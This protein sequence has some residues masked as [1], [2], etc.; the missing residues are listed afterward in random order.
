MLLKKL[1]I[2]NKIYFKRLPTVDIDHTPMCKDY[3]P[4]KYRNN[5]HQICKICDTFPH[6]WEQK[7]QYFPLFPHI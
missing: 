5:S 3:C 1:T 6:E 2:K 7:Y 4:H